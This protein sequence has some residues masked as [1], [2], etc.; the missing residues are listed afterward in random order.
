MEKINREIKKQKNHLL[1]K[2]DKYANDSY[3]A[4]SQISY[5]RKLTKCFDTSEIFRVRNRSR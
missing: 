5:I 2:T 4:K 3:F 1:Y